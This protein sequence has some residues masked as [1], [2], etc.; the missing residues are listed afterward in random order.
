[1]LNEFSD[2]VDVIV[3]MKFALRHRDQTRVFPVGD[4]DLVVRQHGPHGVAQQSGVVAREGR[5]DQHNGLHLEPIQGG[6]VI[7]EALETAQLAK[8][9][10]DFNAFVDGNFLITNGQV[11][12]PNWGF[13]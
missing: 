9:L 6:R 7:A 3:E 10:V 2:V 1:M 5:H 4:V 13:S 12:M 8:R 11:L